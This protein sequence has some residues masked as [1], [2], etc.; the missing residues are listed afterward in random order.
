MEGA[1]DLVELVVVVS[2]SI[3][4]NLA[5]SQCTP[6]AEEG[7]GRPVGATDFAVEPRKHRALAAPA[8]RSICLLTIVVIT[9]IMVWKLRDGP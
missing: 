7:E 2:E 4:P 5:N 6:K 3:E 8:A 9:S 1:S